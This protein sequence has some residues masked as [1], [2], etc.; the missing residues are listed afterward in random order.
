MGPLHLHLPGRPSP[1]PLPSPREARAHSS[2]GPKGNSSR[3]PV[4]DLVPVACGA[5]EASTGPDS[6]CGASGPPPPHHEGSKDSSP[7]L[8]SQGLG[9][10]CRG[11]L[12]PCGVIFWP[13]HP[14][15]RRWLSWVR[16]GPG[17]PCSVP[18][19]QT[20]LS[21]YPRHGGQPQPHQAPAASPPC[22]L[23]GEEI[24]AWRLCRPS[25]HLLVS[26]QTR[27]RH[28]AGAG[29]NHQTRVVGQGQEGRGRG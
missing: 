11:R 28:D 12:F 9:R 1:S 15:Q 19:P 3:L 24:Q 22:S 25:W 18:S 21:S 17:D 5:D 14:R 26:P 20:G 27:F 13:Q 29:G 8:W 4:L 23:S 2:E 10:D 16:E 6:V 7:F